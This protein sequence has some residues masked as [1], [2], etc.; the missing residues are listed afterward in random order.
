MF[1]SGFTFIRNA[2]KFDYPFLE[3][4]RSLLPLVDEL[5]ISAGNSDDKTNELLQSLNNDK[6]K[7]IHSVWDDTLREGGQIL[8]VETNKALDA[9]N[10]EAD[11]A[12]YLQADEVI[13]EDDYL[14]ITSAMKKYLNNKE[15]EGLL[16]SYIHFYGSYKYTGNSRRWYRN[17]IRIIRNDSLIRSYKDAQGFR[18]SG[19]K[20]KV[21][22]IDARIFHY[23]WVKRPADQAAKL[24][25][26]HRLWHDDEKAAKKA[27][28]D[29]F[30]Y[31]GIDSLDMYQ[32]THPQVMN[33][34]I[35][36]LNWEFNFDV[37][38]NHKNL[39]T[40]LLDSIENLTGYRFFEYKN[41]KKI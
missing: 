35:E 12:I 25:N 22:K 19:E 6:I 7:I 34:R 21:K 27:G 28:G 30:D 38:K 9:V 4:I 32:G 33:E 10:P 26:F 13:H 18:K 5:I 1:V 31:S 40:K 39:K 24:K 41:Y 20:L 17:E 36:K 16:F 11:W 8:A 14:N 37:S 15:V 2:V 3:S 23:G 29:E